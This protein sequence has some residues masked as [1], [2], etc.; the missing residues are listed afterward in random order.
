MAFWVDLD[1]RE[2]TIKILPDSKS[3]LTVTVVGA[4]C[5]VGVVMHGIGRVGIRVVIA[6]VA[7]SGICA[8]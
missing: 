2:V 4:V 8:L 3:S 5:L 7:G 1:R 6:I